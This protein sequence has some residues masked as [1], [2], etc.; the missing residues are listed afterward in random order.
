LYKLT[1]Q[2]H[3][4]VTGSS[5]NQ[6][7][8]I[9]P[10]LE[11]LKN[12]LLSRLDPY[13]RFQ[14]QKRGITVIQNIYTGFDTEYELLDNKKNLNK[15]VSTQAAV[16]SRVLIKIPLYKTMDVSYIHPLTSEI[17]NFY[18]PEPDEWHAPDLL[19]S[20]DMDLNGLGDVKG[21]KLDELKIINESLR[22]CT[23]KIRSDLFSTLDCLNTSIIENLKG[24]VGGVIS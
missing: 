1:G 10:E 15:L 5:L 4:P 9:L 21:K 18:K 6:D 22:V 19:T 8:D 17:S 20:A 7:L 14:F 3:H 24:L 23:S 2:I 13:I 11:F 16:Q 12:D